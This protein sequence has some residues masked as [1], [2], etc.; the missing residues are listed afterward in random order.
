MDR[1]TH[2]N[3]LDILPESK[4]MILVIRNKKTTLRISPTAMQSDDCQISALKT[5]YGWALEEPENNTASLAALDLVI[6]WAYKDTLFRQETNTIAEGRANALKNLCKWYA[7]QRGVTLETDTPAPTADY[8][9]S[10]T[11]VKAIRTINN[12]AR[13][14]YPNTKTAI[15]RQDGALSYLCDGNLLVAFEKLPATL[16]EMS[17]ALV[18][19]PDAFRQ[20]D[21]DTLFPG[22]IDERD[23]R[24]S[25]EWADVSV[26]Y[27]FSRYIS[28]STE[29]DPRAVLFPD[30]ETPSL[31]NAC[32]FDAK[33]L[34]DLTDAVGDFR[35]AYVR[36][37]ERWQLRTI[38]I[39]GNH[40]FGFLMPRRYVTT[41]ENILAALER[42]HQELVNFTLAEKKPAPVKSLPAP[43]PQP[44]PTVPE[45]PP[46]PVVPVPT[47][48][49]TKPAPV[50]VDFSALLPIL[51][52]MIARCDRMT[53]TLSSLT[54]TDLDAI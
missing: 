39:F 17:P 41:A 52:R 40:A 10:K 1:P 13:A 50:T 38:V 29:N 32:S 25:E 33:L 23:Y 53:E 12:R 46:A 3:L 30:G 36:K 22:G 7:E 48:Q 35:R 14:A 2:P 4:G 9:I 21:P 31:E 51:D 42:D 5:V 26:N 44:K 49:E 19:S 43:K 20:Y 34:R 24:G 6:P 8:E 18:G 47:P 11:Q 54:E 28:M 45:I 37:A 15:I 16:A 27:N